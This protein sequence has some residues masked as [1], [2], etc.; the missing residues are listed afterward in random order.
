MTED[1]DY[2]LEDPSADRIDEIVDTKIFVAQA[3][4]TEAEA[5][6]LFEKEKIEIFKG[7]F[8]RPKEE[9]IEIKSIKRSFEPYL[10]IGGEYEIRYLTEQTYDIDLNDDAVSVFILGEE[11][12]VPRKEETEE[13][14]V[15]IK[16]KKSGFF[17][18][19]F[20]S[21]KKEPK[22]KP[23]LQLKGIEHVYTKKEIKEAQNYKGKSI[24]P[25]KLFDTPLTEV[26]QSFFQNEGA[27][28]PKEYIDM[29]SFVTNIIDTYAERPE[30]AQRVLFEKL[31]IIDKKI[32]FYPLFWAEMIYKG[33]K[34][35]NV[36]L[37]VASKS[38]EEE[39]GTIYAPPPDVK[40]T[41]TESQIEAGHCPECCS[42]IEADD[43]YCEKCGVK[44]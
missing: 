12:M 7:F 17:D 20:S 41:A 37:D 34:T 27:V 16:K 29:D 24:N 30:I 26:S 2:R 22:T 4:M 11:I 40:P 18:N 36:R 33:S 43:V 39:K 6:E 10:I 1:Y 28:I 31:K 35:K 15:E 21:G 25:E 32:L 23:E 44:L 19:L 8:K 14:E 42:P 5:K 13:I 3:A 38:I 9:E